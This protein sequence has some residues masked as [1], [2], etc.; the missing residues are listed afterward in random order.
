MYNVPLPIAMM[1][2]THV[3]T[4]IPNSPAVEYYFYELGWREDPAE[5]TVIKDGYIEI[6]EKPDLGV[7]L[8]MDIVEEHMVDGET[9]FDGV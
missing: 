7:T 2:P 6:L 3:G 8:D 1:A 4:A 5:E 9:L